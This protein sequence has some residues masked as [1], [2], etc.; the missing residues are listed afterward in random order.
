MLK[1]NIEACLLMVQDCK[2][3]F[4]IFSGKFRAELGV[5]EDL[6]RR[7]LTFSLITSTFMKNFVGRWQ[8]EQPPPLPPS[9]YCN[10]TPTHLIYL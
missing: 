5:K 1:L 4:L 10:S 8:V 3:E 6:Q 7:C 9:G 2:W